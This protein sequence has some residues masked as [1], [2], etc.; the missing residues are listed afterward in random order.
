MQIVYDDEY[1]L[2]VE[3]IFYV[4]AHD[5]DFTNINPLTW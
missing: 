5:S 3:N 2:I 4:V 1:A